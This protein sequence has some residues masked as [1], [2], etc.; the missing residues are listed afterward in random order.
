MVEKNEA[1]LS[2]FYK[3]LRAL[4]KTTFPKKCLTCG[5]IYKTFEDFLKKTEST[6]QTT[7]LQEYE[8][9]KKFVGLFRQCLCHSTLMIPCLDRRDTSPQGE[10]RRKIFE[11]LLK[12]LMEAGLE[13]EK[14]REE[15]LKLLNGEE[16]S[17]LKGL[18][19]D[20]K[21]IFTL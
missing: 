19:I 5:K 21:N 4:E 6:L 11:E 9:E 16:S 13:R 7:G 12:K 3:D 1:W 18:G 17:D 20:I 15:L 2:R 10:K 8:V 14:G